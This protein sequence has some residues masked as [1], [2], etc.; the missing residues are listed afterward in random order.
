[1]Y[2]IIA[3]IVLISAILAF[4]YTQGKESGKIN[5]VIK[6]QEQQ[7]EIQNVIIEERS[8]VNKRKAISK[9][10]NTTDN[11][12]WLRQNSCADCNQDK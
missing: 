11:I 2:K 10:I 6:N 9:T 8:E 5:E 12:E 4:I 7:I 1:M 3:L